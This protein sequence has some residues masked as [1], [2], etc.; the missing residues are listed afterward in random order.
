[1]ATFKMAEQMLPWGLRTFGK[2]LLSLSITDEC[3]LLPR[4][5]TVL[6]VACENVHAQ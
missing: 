3:L 1:M 2:S 4:L 5:F 6:L